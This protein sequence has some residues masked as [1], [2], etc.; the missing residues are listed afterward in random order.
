MATVDAC[1]KRL[2]HVRLDGVNYDIGVREREDGR[3]GVSWVCLYCFEQ[4][5]PSPAA[6]TLEQAV[7]FAHVGLHAHHQ[8]V[9]ADA[10]SHGYELIDMVAAACV[11]DTESS[12]A[13]CRNA[14]ARLRTAFDSL[15]IAHARLRNCG[16]QLGEP[17]DGRFT[18]ACRDWQSMSLEFDAA[19]REYAKELRKRT[20]SLESRLEFSAGQ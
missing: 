3:F 9:H 7:A 5:P 20:L 19:I 11:D 8:L 14:H 13:E 4:G 16:R 15:C 10:R 18:N 2:T 1:W 17:A 6:E 12:D